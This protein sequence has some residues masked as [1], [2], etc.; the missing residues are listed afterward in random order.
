MIEYAQSLRHDDLLIAQQ[1]TASEYSFTQ[2]LSQF[3]LVWFSGWYEKSTDRDSNV[4][5][6]GQ[7]GNVR[8]RR[9][10]ANIIFIIGFLKF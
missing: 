6:H 2:F 10:V 5:S 1:S 3:H 9:D 4:V 7:N 8:P